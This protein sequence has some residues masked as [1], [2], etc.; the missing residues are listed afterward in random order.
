VNERFTLTLARSGRTIEVPADKRA[1]DVLAE[2][3][4]PIDTK[5]SDGIC[6]VCSARVL[7]GQPEH[8]DHVLS[9]KERKQK[10]LLCCSRAVGPGGNIVIDL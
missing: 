1:T 9:K 6:G 7:S 3:G 5:C 10:M 2:L 8:R 4:I